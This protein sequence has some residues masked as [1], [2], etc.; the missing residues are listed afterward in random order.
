MSEADG[1]ATANITAAGDRSIAVGG[2]A[3]NSLLV[4]GDNN[5]FFV[6]R[7]ERL[8]DAY[9]DPRSLFEELDLDAFVGRSWLLAEVDGFTHRHDRGYLVIEAEAGLGKSAFL[10]WLARSRGYVHHFVRLMPDARDVGVAVRN[11]GAQLIRAW[12]LTDKAIG[13]VFPPNAGRPEFLWEALVAAADARDRLRPGEPIVIVVDGLNETTPPPGLNPLGLPAALPHGVFVVASQRPVHVPLRLEVPRLVVSLEASGINNR[14]D[15]RAYLGQAAATPALA[16]RLA[17]TGV[18]QEVFVETLLKRSEGVWIYLHYALAEIAS[19][20]RSPSELDGLPMGLWLYYAQY[21][22]DWQRAHEERWA[23]FDQPL[24]TILAAAAEPLRSSL[25]AELVRH[26]VERVEALLDDEWRPF[27]LVDWEGDAPRYR[28]FHDSLREFANGDVDL[29]QLGSAERSMALRLARGTVAAHAR[30]ADHYLTRWG[31]IT[32]DLASLRD[33]LGTVPAERVLD[34]YR[35][36]LRHVVGHLDAGGRRDDLHALLTVSWPGSDGGA[37]NAWFVF[38]SRAG[39]LASYRADVVL[40]NESA[41]GTNE[42][43]TRQLCYLLILASLNSVAAASPPG[44]WAELVRRGRLPFADGQAEARQIPTPPERAEALTRLLEVTPSAQRNDSEREALAAVAAVNDG[45]W[46]VGELRRLHPLLSAELRAELPAMVAAMADPYYR[47]VAAKVLGLDTGSGHIAGAGREHEA[48]DSPSG[49]AASSEF[50]DGY[51]RRR[52]GVME[53]LRSAGISPLGKF[54][55]VTEAEETYWRA[56]ARLGA[57]TP[58]G[59]G[60]ELSWTCGDQADLVRTWA[61]LGALGAPAP[62]A[63]HD[64]VLRAAVLAAARTAPEGSAR[65]ALAQ[66][67]GE[68]ARVFVLKAVAELPDGPGPAALEGLADTVV[69]ATRRAEVLLAIAARADGETAARL[70]AQALTALPSPPRADLLAMAGAAGSAETRTRAAELAARL[71]DEPTRAALLASLGQAACVAGDRVWVDEPTHAALTEPWRA[72]LDYVLACDDAV[73]GAQGRAVVRAADLPYAGWRATVYAKAAAGLPA[74][75]SAQLLAQIDELTAGFAAADRVAL[76][77]SVATSAREDHGP[78]MLELALETSATIEDPYERSVA[79]LAVV[80][81]LAAR[82][83]AA[84][85]ARLAIEITDD[86]VRTEAYA[87]TLSKMDPAKIEES[88]LDLVLNDSAQPSARRTKLLV[89]AL[90]AS[91]AVAPPNLL[92]A[93][94]AAI[95]THLQGR[96][97]REALQALPALLSAWDRLGHADGVGRVAD[98]LARIVEW[99]P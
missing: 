76:L 32:S 48:E 66:V 89:E 85:A 81:C 12:D 20:V 43:P 45:F 98:D 28:L 17:G 90:S 78:R 93:E 58:D 31:A 18:S 41:S 70:A 65:A 6:G 71:E 94:V 88:T 16:S 50:V 39:E 49:L 72:A 11:L 4:T 53:R 79:L 62:R 14:A 83:E 23:E 40:A 46:R 42:A 95:T 1:G 97:R 64:P 63:L 27:I 52:E 3:I 21:W 13:G 80:T 34:R 5:I 82:G 69:D 68:Q 15:M 47:A 8:V 56:Q 44:L 33:E 19:G 7:Y 24:L 30:I 96:P 54:V 86:E 9:L 99:W 2:D 92:R 36:G 61:S 75:Q 38:H 77:A 74:M 26:P 51:V 91:V 59:E 60:E 73:R 87:A 84:R 10:A 25:L 22:V 55:D 57:E 35:Y 37:A 67:P 29:S